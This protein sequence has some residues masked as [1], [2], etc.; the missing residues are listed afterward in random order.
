MIPGN[1]LAIG[2]AAAFAAGVLCGWNIRDWRADS[3]A[4]AQA[5]A[6]ANEHDRLQG[7]ADDKAD[8]LEAV[9]A[10]HR[11]AAAEAQT[12]IREIYRDVKV[13]ADCAVPD[14]ALGVLDEALRRAATEAAGQPGGPV[15][16]PSPSPS[17]DARP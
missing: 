15:R 13:P 12:Q 4:L 8:K 7:R 14:A 17:G 9:L 6:N 2:G 1:F 10:E 16:A 5:N 11:P 3:D